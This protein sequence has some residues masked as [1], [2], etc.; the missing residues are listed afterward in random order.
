MQAEEYAVYTAVLAQR[1][2]MPD[3]QR[4]V[5]YAATD[6]E[7]P[8]H[9]TALRWRLKLVGL[10]EETLADYFAKNKTGGIVGGEIK[11]SLPVVILSKAET[12]EIWNG[13]DE[14]T[15]SGGERDA[16]QVFYERYPKSGGV[17]RFSRV[18]F[19]AAMSQALVT[20]RTSM[21][22]GR[23][24]GWA[25]LLKRDAELGWTISKEL[26]TQVSCD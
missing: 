19:D 25:L 8:D 18:G 15:M 7:E 21:N 14:A 26:R 13:K 11:A 17:T 6:H 3:G 24:H 9:A 20:M 23:K 12:L 5:V 22:W 2:T 4:I 16:W 10:K 1:P